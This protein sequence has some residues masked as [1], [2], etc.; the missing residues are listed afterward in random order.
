MTSYAISFRIKPGSTERV[1][2]LLSSYAPPAHE[3]ADGARL[4]GTSI[5][6]KDDLVVRTMEVDGP[7]SSIMRHLS[8][9]E[10]I[11]QLERDL[12][13]HLAE[14][15]DM[16][17]PEGARRFFASALMD[18]VVTRGSRAVVANA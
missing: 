11:Q 16:S 4:L 14:P 10:S 13:P 3:T 18:H 5:F 9:Q 8:G 1:K 12:D 17:S 6:V 2:E 15:R 7:L